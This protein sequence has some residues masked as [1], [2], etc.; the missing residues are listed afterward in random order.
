MLQL[1]WNQLYAYLRLGFCAD[2]WLMQVCALETHLASGHALACGQASHCALPYFFATFT[3][4]M[5][6]ST[7]MHQS[8]K[9]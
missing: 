4:L 8:S 1:L 6:Q 9:L 2:W 7:P 5:L 3:L